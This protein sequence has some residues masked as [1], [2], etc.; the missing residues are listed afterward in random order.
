MMVI[1]TV[2][3][4]WCIQHH[5]Y[6]CRPFL[7]ETDDN[8]NDNKTILIYSWYRKNKSKSFYTNLNGSKRLKSTNQQTIAAEIMYLI[9][10]N[11]FGFSLFSFFFPSYI[12][13]VAKKCIPFTS[14]IKQIF[15]GLLLTLNKIPM[16]FDKQLFPIK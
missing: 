6:T 13:L 5:K 14:F 7:L 11:F 12:H 3:P 8:S 9:T 10:Y 1:W 2:E 4:I 15:D 16:Y